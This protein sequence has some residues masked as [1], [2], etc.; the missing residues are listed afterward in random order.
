MKVTTVFL[1]E[2]VA[3]SNQA[4]KKTLPAWRQQE[5]GRKQNFDRRGDFRNRQRLERRRDKF[6][7]L[8]KFPKEI[9]ALYKGK[10]KALPPM[11]AL[12]EKGNSNKLCEFHREVGHNTDECMHLRRQIEELIKNGKLSHAPSESKKPNGPGYYTPYWFQWRSYMANGTNIVVGQNR[13]CGTFNLHM[14]EF[15]GG[16]ITISIQWDHRKTEAQ[17]SNAIQ[18]TKER[19]KVAIHP[20]YPEQTIAIGSTLT[21]ERRKALCDLLR[22]NLDI[23]AWKPADMT[24][25]SRHIA[26]HRLNVREGCLLVR[27]K[28]RSQAPERNKAIQEEVENW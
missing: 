8:T 20:E 14:D 3:A 19:I 4:R 15:R 28:K 24:G 25:V 27:Q 2:E 23:F 5:A 22:R 16:K 17:T 9:L 21:E 18:T 6:T 12:L 11:T 13:R 26:K 7:L 10:F 1:W